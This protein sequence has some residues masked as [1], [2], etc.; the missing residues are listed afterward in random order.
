MSPSKRKYEIIGKSKLLL[1]NM[2][3]QNVNPN[4]DNVV[5]SNLNNLN[6]LI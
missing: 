1:T 3:L 2:E 6:F 4:S 5:P